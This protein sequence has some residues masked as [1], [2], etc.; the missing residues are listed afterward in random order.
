MQV[1]FNIDSVWLENSSNGWT[2]SWAPLISPDY[3]ILVSW[4]S[5]LVTWNVP[6][7]KIWDSLCTTFPYIFCRLLFEV[8]KSGKAKPIETR[9]FLSYFLSDRCNQLQLF[10]VYNRT[11]FLFIENS[12]QLNLWLWTYVI[13][14]IFYFPFVG[15]LQELIFFHFNCFIFRHFYIVLI[16][17]MDNF[18]WNSITGAYLLS[19]TCSK[20]CWK[21]CTTYSC[22]ALVSYFECAFRD[23]LSFTL[24]YSQ[25]DARSFRKCCSYICSANLIKNSNLTLTWL[26]LQS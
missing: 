22:F 26:F 21:A 19:L 18:L 11:F 5:S 10:L 15:P 20:D 8:G 24:E 25:K 7:V 12:A 17:A 2:W 16:K 6:G 23:N 9:R 4:S 14:P 13:R 1:L 3:I